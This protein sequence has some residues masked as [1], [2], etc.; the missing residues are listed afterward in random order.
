[1]WPAAR[2]AGPPRG[3]PTPGPSEPPCAQNPA[4]NENIEKVFYLQVT[5]RNV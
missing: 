4:L 2:E 5:N 3:V 1:M